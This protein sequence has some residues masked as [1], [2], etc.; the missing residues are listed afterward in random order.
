M[1][2]RK[3]SPR[4]FLPLALAFFVFAYYTFVVVQP[5]LRIPALLLTA[6]LVSPTVRII[7][8][9]GDSYIQAANRR[10]AVR[11]FQL[12]KDALVRKNY[13][14]A[15]VRATVGIEYDTGIS[16]LWYVKAVALKN[17]GATQR[18]V[19]S[20]VS[21]ALE[22]GNW[23]DYN[24]DG[25]RIL[26]ADI[27][28]DTMRSGEALGILANPDFIYSNDAEFIRAKCYYRLGDF[29]R[30]RA[31]VGAA[32][33]IYPDDD[34]YL[35]L[36]FQSE[37]LPGYET[38]AE[39]RDIARLY[40]RE[41]LLSN[42]GDAELAI[43]AAAFAE[44][45]DRILLLRAFAGRDLSH[46]LYA[47]FALDDG[48]LDR[49][50]A[51][52]YFM[53]RTAAIL[54]RDLLETF[55]SRI[56]DEASVERLA[57]FLAGYSGS[58][59]ADT[60]GDG[61]VNLVT[62]YEFGRPKR[63]E[64]DEDQDGVFEW[65][66][67]CDFGTPTELLLPPRDMRLTFGRYPSITGA[68]CGGIDFTIPEAS[69]S[70]SPVDIRYSSAL[71]ESP[72]AYRF[73][74]PEPKAQAERLTER[75]L[76]AGAAIITS[77]VPASDGGTIEGETLVFRMADGRPLSVEHFRN[78]RLYARTLFSEGVPRSRILDEDADGIFETTH[79]FAFDEQNSDYFQTPDE[80]RVLYATL[81]GLIPA[82]KGIYL[83]RVMLDTDADTKADFFEEYTGGGGKSSWWDTDG[84]GAWDI[85]SIRYPDSDVEDS[86][87]RVFSSDAPAIV[88]SQKGIPSGVTRD[89][90]SLGITKDG[91]FD[92]Y[93]IGA[94]GDG[95]DSR[96]V[97]D[98]LAGFPAHGSAMVEGETNRIFAVKIGQYK[99]G[100]V[101]K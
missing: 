75:A 61:I 101:V 53:S 34:R 45:Q 82:V 70:W 5:K 89:N 44:G 54:P 67:D 17:T 27:L 87:F 76:Y 39:K 15:L 91:R 38:N 2:Y 36:F 92:F 24:K 93:W 59:S 35:R 85:A 79:E 95:N 62:V 7:A 41:I 8:Q 65:T 63:I 81:F 74:I 99:F 14:E 52:D 31:T 47:L 29:E 96:L 19:F 78:G 18:E 10:T 12:A 16:D 83:S 21:L 50:A 94:E 9:S 40:T 66:A 42:T 51:L 98:A 49:D 88:R 84:D 13:E 80:G 23:I 6:L 64:Y 32:H 77:P 86:M 33:R 58:V 97:S 56:D 72:G 43:L 90:V 20:C 69:L 71:L 37:L 57:A 60:T 11:A 25:A 28:S 1:H 46:P 22:S 30:A 68:R 48:L 3:Q 55:A 26:A 100:E 4:R 73:F